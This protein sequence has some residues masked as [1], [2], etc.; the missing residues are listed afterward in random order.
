MGEN[1]NVDL[2]CPQTSL[3]AYQ[4]FDNYSGLKTMKGWTWLSRKK[5]TSSLYPRNVQF[6][7]WEDKH[8]SVYV[9]V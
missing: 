5:M 6:G 4:Y 3:N 1:L 7:H 9:V 8:L 2:K